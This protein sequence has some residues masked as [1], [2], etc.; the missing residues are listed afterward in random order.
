LEVFRDSEG[1]PRRV[2]GELKVLGVGEHTSSAVIVRSKYHYRRGDRFSFKERPDLADL[3]QA[4]A[5]T[6]A[7]TAVGAE[8]SQQVEAP[9]VPNPATVE[10]E[11]VDAGERQKLVLQGLVD[12]LEFDSGE[13]TIKPE[14]I[15]ILNEVSQALG[16]VSEKQVK[17]EGHTDNVPIGPTLSQTYPSNWELSQARAEEVVR[18]LVEKAGVD[19]NTLSSV[20]QAE[21][22]PIA[23]NATEE[24]RQKNRRVEILVYSPNSP[25]ASPHTTSDSGDELLQD[26]TQSELQKEIESL[27]S[28]P[29]VDLEPLA[30]GQEEPSAPLTDFDSLPPDMLNE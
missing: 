20:G 26:D 5:G 28:E 14:G 19:S 24:G 16:D 9:A 3:Q 1:L 27:L 21:T 30:D 2:I 18:Y 4:S 11:S 10:P 13:V 12:Q 23:S 15:K 25:G 8:D 29:D 7:A 17:V 22:Q 6:G